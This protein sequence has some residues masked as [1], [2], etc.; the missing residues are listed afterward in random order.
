MPYYPSLVRLPA[1]K[2]K[3]VAEGL[4]RLKSS[5][6]EDGFPAKGVDG[7]LL[8]ATWNIR[9]FGGRKYGGRDD[10]PLYYLAEI[11]SRFDLVAVQEVRDDLANLQRV[12]QILGSWWKVLFTDVTAGTR[13]NKER[14][15]FLY[16][17]RKIIF[18]GLAGEIVLPP[19]KGAKKISSEQL[20]RTPMIV[21]FR[22]GWFKFTIC[23]AHLYYGGSKPDDPRRLQEMREL[24]KFLAREAKARTA[25]AKN[26]IVLGDF[27][28]FKITDETFKTL[29]LSGFTVPP[30][31]LEL[32]S[33]V[34]GDRHFDQIAFIA[35][36]LQDQLEH[37]RSGVFRF[38]DHVYRDEDE[39]AYKSE[40]GSAR[41]KDWR[42]YKMSDHFPLWVEL[43]TDFGAKY[44]TRLVG[45]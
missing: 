16:D 44:L 11:I 37:A 19:L 41:Y 7:N 33:N 5:F 15:G 8:L 22:A 35:P 34:A 39:A 40:F 1:T 18:G 43:Q 36:S 30:G 25:W 6:A 21:G 31:I 3:R 17:S 12:M 2:R 4:L 45:T 38:R 27:N 26:M 42:T 29:T 32:T 24:A 14:T 13:G 23:T 9:E 10:E 20:A 28:I